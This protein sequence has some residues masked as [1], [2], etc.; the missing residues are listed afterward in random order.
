MAPY[1]V[2]LGDVV[3]SQNIDNR[4]DF[5]TALEYTLSLVNEQYPSA[6]HA[7][8]KTLKGID[9]FGGV[10]RSVAPIVDIQKTISREIHP[11]SARIAAVVGDIDVN[12]S[13][14]D[15]AQMDG[16]AFA[17]ADVILSELETEA[18]TFRLSGKEP[19]T[20]ELISD[21]VNLLDIIREGWSQRQMEVVTQYEREGSQKAVAD[22]L[23]IST[24]AVS[25]HLNKANISRVRTIEQRIS[26]NV[27]QYDRLAADE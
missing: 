17:R 10:L 3:D 21:L 24:Q 6:I 25:K 15:I 18:L 13:A 2:V 5:K 26:S 9:E 11:E 23:G 12:R 27:H 16:M 8:F 22:E 19:Q 20:D 7:P 4:S 14:T 1:C